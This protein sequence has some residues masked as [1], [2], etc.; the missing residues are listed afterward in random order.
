MLSP[1]LEHLLAQHCAPALL[2]NKAA[3]LVAL[4]HRE[5]PD[6]QAAAALCAREFSGC[7]LAFR[8]L[9]TCGRYSQLLVYRPALLVRRLRQPHTQRLLGAYG[10]PVG[11]G[12]EQL[13]TALQGRFAAGAGFPHEIGLFLDFPPADVEGFIR[14]RGEACKLCGYWKV[15]ADVEEAR[16]RFACFDA[17]RHCL[18]AAV[19]AGHSLPTLLK[20][21]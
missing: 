15:Y 19:A 12:V 10:Y 1:S 9:C 7:G 4:P 21:A 3:N 18:C 13:L 11:A 14:S 20:A 17:C 16:I 6:P 8:V 5:F 2:G